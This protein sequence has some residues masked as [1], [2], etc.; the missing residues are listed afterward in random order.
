M[1]WIFLGILDF[2]A[3]QRDLLG[4]TF[5]PPYRLPGKIQRKRQIQIRIGHLVG[6]IVESDPIPIHVGKFAEGPPCFFAF[7]RLQ[8]CEPKR[9]CRTG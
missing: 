6:H 4:F 5:Y 1:V 2:Q 7:P 9:A 3:C 8:I